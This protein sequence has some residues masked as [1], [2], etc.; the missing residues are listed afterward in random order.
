MNSYEKLRQVAAEDNIEIISRPFQSERIRGLY[1]DGTIAINQN[2]TTEA[3]KSCI[4]AEELGHHYT[5]TGN[6]LDQKSDWNRKQEYRARLYGYN[7][8]I[9]LTGIVEAYEHGCQS[10]YEMAEYLEVTEKY[11]EECICCY[12]KK[13]GV[14]TAVNNYIV[15]FIPSLTVCKMV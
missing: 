13:Y 6:I 3:E 2:I 15:Y 10:R 8:R 5:T 11:L 9:G 1:C 7:L 14:C 12:R 4:L